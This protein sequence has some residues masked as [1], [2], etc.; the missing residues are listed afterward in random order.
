MLISYLRIV[1]WNQCHSIL[2]SSR[3]TILC[4]DVFTLEYSQQLVSC[5]INIAGPERENQ[6]ARQNHFLQPCS[7]A[8]KF[9]DVFNVAVLPVPE[10]VPALAV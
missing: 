2:P 9:A 7:G 10:I 5:L 1:L 6:V 3:R 8:R 4:L